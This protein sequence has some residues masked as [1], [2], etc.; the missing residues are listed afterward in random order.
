MYRLIVKLNSID[1]Y[2]IV[3]PTRP[4]CEAPAP[5]YYTDIDI[6]AIYLWKCRKRDLFIK[7]LKEF[8]D[9]R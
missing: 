6:D 4:K 1:G 3:Q 8:L 2:R 9:G 7:N 5:N